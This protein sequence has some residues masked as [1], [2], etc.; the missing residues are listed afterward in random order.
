M[1]A[2]KEYDMDTASPPT[3]PSDS[4]IE[5]QQQCPISESEKTVPVIKGLGWL[6]RFLAVWILLAMIIG[7]LLGNFVPETG[8][9]LQKGKFVGVSV[10]I[11]LGLLVMM[12]PILCKVRYET[13]HILFRK[14]ALWIQIGFSIFMN[15]IVAPLLMVRCIPR[16]KLASTNALYIARSCVGVSTGQ[17]RLADRTRF[18]GSSEVHRHG[19]SHTFSLQLQRNAHTH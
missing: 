14:R 11:A 18:G 7:I 10:P 4:D 9:A 1:S 17:K 6:D 8:P 15:W 5:A 2:P 12:Y 13:L 16:F 19:R 3:K